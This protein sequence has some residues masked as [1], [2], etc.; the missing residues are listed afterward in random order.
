MNCIERSARIRKFSIAA[1]GIVLLL[2]ALLPRDTIAQAHSNDAT[3]ITRAVE[4]FHGAL[5]LGDRTA[6]LALLA[7]DALILESGE[8][9]MR[10]EYEREHLAEDI[11]FVSATKTERSPLVIRQD[12]NVAW[13]TATSKTTGTFKGRKIDSTGVELIVLTKGGSGWRIH[14]IHWSSRKTKQ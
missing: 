3:E 9:Q 8:S 5:A 4:G 2:V 11:A 13:T 14:A 6:A 1:A 10:A 7:P 12:G